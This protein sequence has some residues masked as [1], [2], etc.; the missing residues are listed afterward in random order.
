MNRVQQQIAEAHERT[1]GMLAEALRRDPQINSRFSEVVAGHIGQDV[2]AR[3]DVATIE[4]LH[5]RFGQEFPISGDHIARHHAAI[6][7][8]AAV[9][10]AAVGPTFDELVR[11]DGTELPDNVA[12]IRHR[13]GAHHRG[14][15]S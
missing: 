5:E 15:R 9:G 13:R 1:L 2:D 12:P 8:D 10:L 11:A 3:A 6:L 7:R 14:G 4:Y